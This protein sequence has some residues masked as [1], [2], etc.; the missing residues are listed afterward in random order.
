MSLLDL[1][2]NYGKILRYI[3]EVIY[4]DKLA[5]EIQNAIKI[6]KELFY[7]SWVIDKLTQI[8]SPHEI[9][10]ILKNARLRDIYEWH[11]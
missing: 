3:K 4:L 1:L 2:V 9:V 6:S 11:D 7:P 8:E 10:A 5:I